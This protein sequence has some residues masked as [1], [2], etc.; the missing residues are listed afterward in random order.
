MPP[1]I[2]V[3]DNSTLFFVNIVYNSERSWPEGNKM[4]KSKEM[5]IRLDIAPPP[6]F[7]Y[8]RYLRTYPEAS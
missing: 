2:F 7:S 1:I 5:N 4:P 6:V 3:I 8:F